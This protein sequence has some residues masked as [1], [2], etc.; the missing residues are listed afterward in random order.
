MRRTGIK[1]EGFELGE[2]LF[3][4]ILSSRSGLAF[5]HVEYEETWQLL[6]HA[7]KRV[8][9]AVPELLDWLGRL[10]PAAAEPDPD[11]P[12]M[13]IGGQRRN[14]NANQIIR[15][16]RWRKTDPGGALHLHPD[17]L[18]AVGGAKGDWMAVVTRIGRLVV[19]VEADENLR[20]GQAALPHGYGQ[21]FDTPAGPVTVGPRLNLI[22]D[23]EDCDPIARTPYHKN[24]AVRVERATS[25]EIHVAE[26]QEAR[27]PLIA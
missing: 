20:R 15:D 21:M 7:D 16:P 17:D 2:N 10:D 26:E 13:L 9:L 8:R 14:Y 11:Y 1:G 18:E 19:R 25:H 24:V 6:R 12:L 4:A 3:A 5:S 22:T 27:V 23:C